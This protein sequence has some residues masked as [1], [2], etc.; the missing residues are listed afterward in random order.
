M[1]RKT[2]RATK[3]V[4]VAALVAGVLPCTPPAN[5][6]EKA[7]LPRNDI[8]VTA[9]PSGGA[10]HNI[11]DRL[12]DSHTAGIYLDQGRFVITVTD[13]QTADAV[14]DAGAIPK[15]VA[16]DGVYLD[17]IKQKLDATFRTPG[18]TWGVDVPANQVI[19][20]ANSTVSEANFTALSDFIAPYGTAARIERIGGQTTKTELSGINGGD[21]INNATTQCSYG[22]TVQKKTDPSYKAIITAGHCTINPGNDWYKS[23]GNYIGYTIGHNVANGND[24]G[25]IRAYNFD[26]VTYYGNVEAQNGQAQDIA[27]SRDSR[28]YEHVCTSGYRSGFAC[29]L[30][31]AK[32][33]TINWDDG[34]PQSTG[35]DVANICRNHGDSGGPLYDGDAALGILV[36]SNDGSCYSYYQPVNEA[37]DWYG[38]EVY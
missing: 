23:D 13:G 8:A 28:I 14:K 32:N 33:Q 20:R 15:Q 1:A 31:G 38:M 21:Y 25:L 35:M 2:L 36:G 27:Y 9:G 4:A 34:S 16:Y 17:S 10:A 7:D 18:T 30:V 11:A 6:A 5:A 26:H 37:L 12:G 24:F 19:V 22:F 3:A 29:G